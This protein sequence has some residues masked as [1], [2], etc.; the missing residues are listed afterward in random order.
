M[1]DCA[2]IFRSHLYVSLQETLDNHSSVRSCAKEKH[3]ILRVVNFKARLSVTY[4]LIH[5]LFRSLFAYLSLCHGKR[6]VLV[7]TQ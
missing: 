3:H 1:H 6:V 5:G 7:I 2:L 4:G